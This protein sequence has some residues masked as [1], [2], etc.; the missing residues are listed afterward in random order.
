MCIETEPPIRMSSLDGRC[1]YCGM[2]YIYPSCLNRHEAQCTQK[3]VEQE[4]KKRG[5][6]LKRKQTE[7]LPP[8]SSPSL[9]YGAR[10]H[11]CQETV[12][13]NSSDINAKVLAHDLLLLEAQK[14]GV[15]ANHKSRILI[16]DHKKMGTAHFLSANGLKGRINVCEH[17]SDVFADQKKVV[18]SH[19]DMI[20]S[21][22]NL[23]LSE[24]V[25]SRP[26]GHPHPFGLMFWDTMAGWQKLRDAVEHAFDTPTFLDECVVWGITLSLRAGGRRGIDHKSEDVKE[27]RS[28]HV[29]LAANICAIT[30]LATAHHYN[31]RFVDVRSDEQKMSFQNNVQR[32]VEDVDLFSRYSTGMA[33]FLFVL[34]KQH[35][36]AISSAAP[37]VASA[38][39]VVASAAPVAPPVTVTTVSD[40]ERAVAER[41]QNLANKRRRLDIL[42]TRL[43]ELKKQDQDQELR[44]LQLLRALGDRSHK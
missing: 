1:Q 41:E 39:P 9:C 38:A 17:D 27:S 43:E 24:F 23:S 36:G 13:E 42:S 19:P 35:S 4:K 21:H 5:R 32:D 31:I 44:A 2:K 6:P 28:H 34:T 7:L 15:L 37:V 18:T 30:K 8:K 14:A 40:L 11:K 25:T 22:H 29:T 12:Y 3:P 26:G 10:C 33:F 16:L 20:E